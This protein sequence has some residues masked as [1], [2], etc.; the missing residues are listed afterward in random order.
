[1]ADGFTTSHHVSHCCATYSSSH[2]NR[3]FP[4]GVPAHFVACLLE[5][6]VRFRFSSSTGEFIVCEFIVFLFSV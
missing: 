4:C 1:M 2:G 3:I 5:Q 6:F